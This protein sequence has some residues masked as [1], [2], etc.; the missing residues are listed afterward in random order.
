MR[1]LFFF[2]TDFF[3]LLLTF[4]LLD[5]PFLCALKICEAPECVF[6]SFMTLRFYGSIILKKL[7]TGTLSYLVTSV[8]SS[9]IADRWGE[10]PPSGDATGWAYTFMSRDSERVPGIARCLLTWILVGCSLVFIWWR[11]SLTKSVSF[12]IG[13]R[14]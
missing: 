5:V 6:S 11:I 2:S 9:L 4:N 3:L 12:L 14:I 7:S 1:S 13:I 10:L 8:V